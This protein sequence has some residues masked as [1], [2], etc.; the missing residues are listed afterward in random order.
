MTAVDVARL[1]MVDVESNVPDE[2]RVMFDKFIGQRGRVPNLFRIAA[3]RPTIAQTLAAHLDAVMGPGEVTTQLKEL[4][5]CRVS[6]INHTPYCLASHSKLARRAGATDAQLSALAGQDFSAFEPG[7]S[8]AFAY[9][10]EVAAATLPTRPSRR[11][12]S[13][14]RHH[15]SSR[16]PRSRRRSVSSIAS[17]TR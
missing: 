4:I 14:G 1:P 13:I 9:A 17:P 6:E 8:A 15:R 10:S 5:A 12:P 2:T 7:W 3:L 16:L 11:W